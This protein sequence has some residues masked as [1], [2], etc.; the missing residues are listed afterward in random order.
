MSVTGDGKSGT[1][2]KHSLNYAKTADKNVWSP[3]EVNAQKDLDF[4]SEIVGLD[5]HNP[6]DNG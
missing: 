3:R 1:G 2:N 5:H 4:K 6:T